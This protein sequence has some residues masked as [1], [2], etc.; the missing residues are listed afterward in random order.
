MVTFRSPKQR[1]QMGPTY[2]SLVLRTP[3]QSARAQRSQISFAQIPPRV[4]PYRTGLWYMDLDGLSACSCAGISFSVAGV[5]LPPRAARTWN[6]VNIA[7]RP[8]QRR[9]GIRRA[10]IRERAAA[11]APAVERYASPLRGCSDRFE[12]Q[13]A[14]ARRDGGAGRGRASIQ[15]PAWA[16][17]RRQGLGQGPGPGPGQG[18]WTWSRP[19]AATVFATCAAA[20][21]ARAA[22]GC[23]CRRC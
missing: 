4:N 21:T 22:A 6:A 10:T 20:T 5:T 3:Y 11:A 12:C 19:W 2:T 18:P 14:P 13:L 23:G 9:H 8:H 16:R 1:A 17:A 15:G 7:S